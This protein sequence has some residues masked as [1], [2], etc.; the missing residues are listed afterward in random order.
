VFGDIMPRR[1]FGSKG[2]EVTGGWRKL[3][4]RS[5]VIC[6]PPHYQKIKEEEVCRTCSIRKGMRS[7]H[8]ILEGKPDVTPLG[9]LSHRR[10]HNIKMRVKQIGLDDV[11]WIYLIQDTD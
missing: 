5:F 9:R 7:A 1:I 11:D 2:E 10:E 4:V 6:T 3:T 8:N